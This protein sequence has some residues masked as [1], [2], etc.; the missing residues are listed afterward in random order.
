[1]GFIGGALGI[2]ILTL[3]SPDGDN[4][5]LDGSVYRNRSKLEVLFG[6]E[7][8]NE[9]RGKTVIDFG[10]GVGDESI[11][12][13]Q[14]GAARVIGLDIRKKFLEQARGRAQAAGLSDRVSFAA[15]TDEPADVVVSLDCFEHYEDPAGVLETMARCLKPN[16]KVLVSFSTVWYHPYGGHLFAVFPWAH[17]LFTEHAML[18]WRKQIHPQQTAR[19]VKECGL[20]KMTIRRFEKLVTRSP[21]AF[22]DYETRPIR[23]ARLL[24]NPLTREF[25]TSLIRATL[26]PQPAVEL[27]TAPFERGTRGAPS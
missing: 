13:V 18:A 9:I 24:C 14:R 3:L 26:V 17:L 25:L 2:R 22:A 8:F 1:M 5:N 20:N 4:P 11:E 6:P 23:R 21:L 12:M 10:C 19:T 15:S 7:F 16:G 27:A